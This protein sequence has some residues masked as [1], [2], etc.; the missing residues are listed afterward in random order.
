MIAA[1]IKYLRTHS[2]LNQTEFAKLFNLTRGKVDSYERSVAKPSTKTIHAIAKHYGLTV[3]LLNTKS[4]K[5]NPVLLQ[6]QLSVNDLNQAAIK[7]L[8][9]TKDELIKEQKETI[10]FLKIQIEKS[11]KKVTKSK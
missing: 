9:K 11:T 2:G 1:N 6:R 4:I 5:E 3:E 10:K 7:H 8:L